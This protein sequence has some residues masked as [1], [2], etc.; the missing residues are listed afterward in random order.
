MNTK[1]IEDIYELTPVQ[2]GMLFHCL[3]D[4]KLSLYFFQ[5]IFIVRGNLNIEFFEKAWQL[6][7]DRHPIL[8]TWFYWEEIENPLQI[9]YNQVEVPLNLHDW[10][11]INT[12]EQEAQFQSFLLSDRQKSFD[13]SQPCLMRHTLI[14]LTD[15]C[16]R[17]I[18]SVNHIILDGWGG[19]LVFQE[20][21]E[22]Y[23]ALCKDKEI[24]LAPTRPFRDYIDWLQQQD[25]SKAE[26]FWR[27]ALQGV[28][29]PTPL[30]YIEKIN[31]SSTEE[32][33]YS[34]EIIQLSLT[35]TQA[36]QSFA[37]QHR[38]TLA[39]IINGI[40]VIL[41]SRYTC[42]N[43]ILYGYNVA[44]RPVELNGVESMVGMFVNTLPI[45]V[46]IDA[47]LLFLSWLQ[48]FQLQL[49]E[50][51]CYEYTPLTEIHR[52]SEVPQ[53][54]TLFESIVVIENFPVSE[55]IRDWK[56]N[57]EFQHTGLYYRNNYPLN[58]V[59][60]PNKELLIAISYD[61][62]RFDTD[63]IT[64]ILEDIE[65]LLQELMTNSNIQIKY[66]PFLT[67]EQQQVTSI[68]EKE[69]LFY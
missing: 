68:L 29:A 34:E 20:F 65:I 56:G 67:L 25:I 57:I 58:L 33:R 23:G 18:W 5:H 42:R 53:K 63:T 37:A 41:L 62:I 14:R 52:W 26:L 47:E 31:Q 9:V 55:F 22:V 61:S 21:V 49:A 48:C 50:V 10:S 24:C 6:V 38:L 45:Q 2:K 43:N 54:L 12:V 8:R 15:D 27:Q 69:T 32:V 19:S 17:Y 40:W 36:L 4:S 59:V 44:G 13:F 11:N 46:N 35:S 51:R 30:T 66:L 16:Y 28:K 64:G 3:F 7:M 60:Y 39:T 1:T